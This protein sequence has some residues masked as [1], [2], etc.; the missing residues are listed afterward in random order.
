MVLTAQIGRGVVLSESTLRWYVDNF[1]L[2]L[3]SLDPVTIQECGEGWWMKTKNVYISQ[4][5]SNIHALIIVQ[6]K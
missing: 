4:F 1:N 6:D 5:R 2:S 3:N